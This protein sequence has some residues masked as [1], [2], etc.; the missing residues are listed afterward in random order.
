MANI[1]YL[2]YMKFSLTFTE[3]VVPMIIFETF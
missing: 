3:R 1:G 2:E